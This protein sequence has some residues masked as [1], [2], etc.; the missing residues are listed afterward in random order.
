MFSYGKRLFTALKSAI[1]RMEESVPRIAYTNLSSYYTIES[2]LCST[3]E[4]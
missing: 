4:V 1:C 3:T 2:L